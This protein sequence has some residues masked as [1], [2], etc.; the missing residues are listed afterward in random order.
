MSSYSLSFY[1]TDAVQYT[2]NLSTGIVTKTIVG[3]RNLV[4]KTG[5]RTDTVR[6][7]KPSDLLA[8]PTAFT[9][10]QRVSTW[11][12]VVSPHLFGGVGSGAYETWTVAPSSWFM[13]TD[14]TPT[15]ASPGPTVDGKL[16]AK[17]KQ[18]SF[19]LAQNLAEYRQA[20]SMFGK[21]ASDVVS[22]F[23]TLRSGRG[24]EKFIRALQSPRT[25][26]EKALANRWLE[27]QFGLSPLMSDLYEAS[28]WTANKIRQGFPR[29]AE[30]SHTNRLRSVTNGGNNNGWAECRFY[31]ERTVRK[32]AA[33]WI[34]DES[35]AQLAQVGI[36]NPALLAWELVP[37]SFVIDWAI[38]IGNW[39]SSLD[40]LVAVRDMKIVVTDYKFKKLESSDCCG[41]HNKAQSYNRSSARTVQ[42]TLG[43]PRLTYKPSES[44]KAVLNGLA[45]LRQIRR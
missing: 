4:L 45:L 19:N 3:N 33:Y 42:T 31:E 15:L 9:T 26:K 43:L 28:E 12:V 7:V 35:L 2:R 23:H 21:F 25:R 27:Y 37:Y 29:I 34:R 40:A 22:V 17:I 44:L 41:E 11:D 39:L 30:A 8:N 20:C 6:R 16:R 14:T 36:T 32:K 24:F 38:P 5:S 1:P 13:N 18:E 10:S